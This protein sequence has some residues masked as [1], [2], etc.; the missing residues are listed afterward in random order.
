MGSGASSSRLRRALVIRAYNM[1]P[2]TQTME[3][4]FRQY[5]TRSNNKSATDSPN[6]NLIITVQSVKKC[7]QLGPEFGWVDELLKSGLNY[8]D[9]EINFHEFLRFL[10]TGKIA[11]N[12]NYSS[13]NS[14]NNNN[15]HILPGKDNSLSSKFSKDSKK[16]PPFPTMNP[17]SSTTT[18]GISFPVPPRANVA[19][20]EIFHI[21]IS[22]ISKGLGLNDLPESIKL[23]NDNN[24]L[25]NGNDR[26]E[27]LTM[28]IHPSRSRDDV[29]NPQQPLWR[30]REIVKHE[31]TVLYTTVDPEGGT[32]ELVEKEITESEILHM[33]NRATGEFAHREITLYQQQETFNAEIVTEADGVEEYVHFKSLED[34]FQHLHSTMPRGAAGPPA[35][36]N[37]KEGDTTDNISPLSPDKELTSNE[38]SNKNN[39]EYV[40]SNYHNE[41]RLSP[42]LSPHE[43][44]SPQ[45]DP[46]IINSPHKINKII[47]ENEPIII[48]NEPENIIEKTDS[49]FADID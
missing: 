21:N 17:S 39:D 43:P 28:I 49:N 14:N 22:D 41:N 37:P 16:L 4:Q 3:E 48:I 24:N 34:E 42:Q 13:N 29:S 32:Q 45:Y 9:D 23:H 46:I 33:E 6:S 15:V 40:Y 5:A 26:A 12:S 31:R 47:F 8:K 2:P 30:K 7:L 1:R 19:E 20:E 35:P 25:F 36:S 27:S 10:E 44:P 11:A 18:D 38:N